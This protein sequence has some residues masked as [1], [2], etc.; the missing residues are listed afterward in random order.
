MLSYVLSKHRVVWNGTRVS[1]A[2][3]HPLSPLHLADPSSFG[4]LD[5]PSGVQLRVTTR[6][7]KTWFDQLAVHQD[8]GDY[9]GRPWVS[10]SELLEQGVTHDEIL[11]FDGPSD[12]DS[13]VPCSKVWPMGFS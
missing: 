9:F 1:L 13:F 12:L 3:S 6:D 11:S 8:I 4:L 10:R 7:C 5:V 2:A